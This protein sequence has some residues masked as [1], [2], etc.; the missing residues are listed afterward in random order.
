MTKSEAL[1][2]VW[3]LVENDKIREAEAIAREFGIEMCF[4]ENYIGIED[5][6]FYF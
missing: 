6:V 4:D 2:E 3:N 1:K 5:D